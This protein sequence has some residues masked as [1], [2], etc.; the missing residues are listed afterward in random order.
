[1]TVRELLETVRRM[2]GEVNAAEERLAQIR[3][4][5]ILLK[6]PKLGERVQTSPQGG[7]ENVISR[8]EEQEKITLEKWGQLMEM[9]KRADMVIDL[10]PDYNEQATLTKYYIVGKTMEQV[11][12]DLYYSRNGITDVR[13]RALAF[14]EKLP[15]AKELAELGMPPV[16]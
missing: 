9:R 13:N 14:L 1:M 15:E 12:A 10:L 7:L 2:T 5:A 16:I 11:G 8:M 3:A 4:E 6:S